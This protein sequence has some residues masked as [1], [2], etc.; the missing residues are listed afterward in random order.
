METNEL[1]SSISSQTNLL[2]MNAAIEAAHAG[3]A[4]RGFAVVAE[5]IR[6]LAE[7]TG[8]QSKQT[9]TELGGIMDSIRGAVETS[10]TVLQ[11]FGQI[12]DSVDKFSREL[13]AVKAVIYRQMTESS[14]IR[15]HL[16]EMG[17]STRAVHADTDALGT[18]S[19]QSHASMQEL[20]EMSRTVHQSVGEMID[21]TRALKEVLGKVHEVQTG[22][23][24]ALDDLIGLVAGK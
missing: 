10:V 1:I 18:E 11:G 8:E 7:E 13:E 23:R 20:E 6:K 9:A 21:R 14:S 2:S 15:S 5:E 22:N 3:E 19:D 16:Q 24:N 4:G 12:R 17:E